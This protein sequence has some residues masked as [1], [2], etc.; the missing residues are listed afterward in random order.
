VATEAAAR[1]VA[2]QAGGLPVAVEMVAARWRAMQARPGPDSEPVSGRDPASALDPVQRAVDEA[3]MF[4]SA[5]ADDLFRHSVSL[6]GGMSTALTE[7]LVG[8]DPAGRDLPEHARAARRARALRELVSGS[9]LVTATTDHGV[10]YR[11]LQPV[12]DARRAWVSDADE[13]ATMTAVADW[14]QGRMRPSYLEAPDPA[15]L[16][17]VIAEWINLDAVLAWLERHDPRRLMELGVALSDVWDVTG[18]GA[19]GH[20]WV[21]RA[22]HRLGPHDVDDVMRARAL[23]CFHTSRGLAYVAAHGPSV[24]E[25]RALLE[26]AGAQGSD[27]WGVVH[28]QLAVVNG[29][30]NDLEGMEQAIAVTHAVARRSRSPWFTALVTELDGMAWLVRGE[31]ARGVA[32]TLEAAEMFEAVGDIDNA[33]NAGYFSCVL[34]RFADLADRDQERLLALGEERAAATGLAKVTALVAGERA[35]F[36]IAR[37]QTDRAEELAAALALTEQAGNFHHAAVGRRDLG[38]L[39]LAEGRGEEAAPYLREATRHLARLD[40]GACSLAVAGLASLHSGEAA[41][42]LGS[43]AWTFARQAQGMPLT[44]VDLDALRRLAGGEPASPTQVGDAAA[45]VSDLLDLQLAVPSS[46]LFPA[47]PPDGAGWGS[48]AT[49]HSSDG[50]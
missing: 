29:W 49:R 21:D 48:G 2:E 44:D 47:V 15:R 40:L 34:G 22:L 16:R 27:I 7:A 50:N 12:V 8:A 14:M 23:V 11:A 1:R 18:R 3:V 31:P 13:G 10:R 5:E 6:P 19:A 4:L 32:L 46:P 24:R 28:A 41:R 33:A 9:L 45:L 17:Q 38:L 43:A 26:R 36:G 42:R 35:R 20:R 39:L 30:H 37:G 25:A